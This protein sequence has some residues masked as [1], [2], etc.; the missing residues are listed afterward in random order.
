VESKEAKETEASDL[1]LEACHQFFPK[2]GVLQLV[3][4]F[5]LI[6]SISFAQNNSFFYSDQAYAED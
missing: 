6:L 3:A 2:L 4:I 5:P 1:D